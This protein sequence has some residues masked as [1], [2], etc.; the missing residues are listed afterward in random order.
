[1]AAAVVV[2]GGVGVWWFVL[3]D[4][5]PPKANVNAITQPTDR[6]TGTARTTP[7][8]SW[9][10]RRG[11]TVF[12][13]YRIRELFAAATVKRTATGRTPLVSGTMSVAGRTVSTADVTADVTALT[14]DQARRDS[15]IR[16]RGLETERFPQATFRLTAPVTLPSDPV[17]GR[18]Y[19]LD[20]TGDLTLH[21]VTRS[22][23]VPLDARWS[24]ATI[25]VAGS[26]PVTL[27]DYGMSAIRIP[28]LVQTDDSGSL[29][30]Q[31]LFVPA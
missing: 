3:R 1:V 2:L 9:I 18:T 30:L 7:N 21:G 23:Q 31:L 24:G 14:S 17:R 27:A 11:R 22:V 8:G 16:E 15:A 13:G 4:T 19:H 6:V 26:A 12:V 25:S 5:A 28:G 20:T 10:V 29:E